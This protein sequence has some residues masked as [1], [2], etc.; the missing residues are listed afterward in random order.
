MQRDDGT[1]EV[2]VEIASMARHY[3]LFDARD[4]ATMTFRGGVGPSV[5]GIGVWALPCAPAL[6][7]R[8]D[9]ELC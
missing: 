8:N 1:F 2:A 4:P 5:L 3:H 9:A 7:S 6:V